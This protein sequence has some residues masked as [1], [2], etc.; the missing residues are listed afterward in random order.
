MPLSDG[1]IPL[2]FLEVRISGLRETVL[3]LR[4][5]P[6]GKD[7]GE[8]QSPLLDK[9]MKAAVYRGG[10]P[11]ESRERLGEAL[12]YTPPVSAFLRYQKQDERTQVPVPAALE[13]PHIDL[14]PF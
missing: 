12:A 11:F 3:L 13:N 5:P 7:P 9:R 10:V 4:L 14:L 6:L 8:G 2:P 1:D